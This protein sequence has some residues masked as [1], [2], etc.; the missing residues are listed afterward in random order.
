V[1]WEEVEAWASNPT[2]IEVGA[3]AVGT[4]FCGR[5]KF[6]STIP[7]LMAA[8]AF[9]MEEPAEEYSQATSSSAPL[10]LVS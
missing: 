4:T 3:P 7:D 5:Y 6:F 10:L 8:L 1:I 9:A 2:M